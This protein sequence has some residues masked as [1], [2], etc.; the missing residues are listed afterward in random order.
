MAVPVRPGDSFDL[1]A[2]VE[3]WES[4][5]RLAARETD[6]SIGQVV[7]HMQGQGPK[8]PSSAPTGPPVKP[9]K[10]QPDSASD[11]GNGRKRWGGGDD[12]SPSRVLPTGTPVAFDRSR[13]GGGSKTPP[14]Y[15]AIDGSGFDAPR[16]DPNKYFKRDELEM[17]KWLSDPKRGDQR[18]F[19]RSVSE[20]FPGKSPDALID[21]VRRTVEFKTIEVKSANPRRALYDQLRASRFQSRLVAADVRNG[22]AS[23]AEAAQAVV[24]L[25]RNG[26][27][28]LD[29][30]VV[31][32]DSF[33][34][35]WPQGR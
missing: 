26:G 6:G 31:V 13:L 19:V 29:E 7:A 12:A 9:P 4:Q 35:S 15:D 16:D 21:Q 10:P 25:L 33:V 8:R 2:Y 34:L 11:D 30:V 5:Y 3:R 14:S 18:V 20:N 32:G 1:P 24:D 22:K 27:L 28:D 17:A 23:Q